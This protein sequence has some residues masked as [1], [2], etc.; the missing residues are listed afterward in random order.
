MELRDKNHPSILIWSLGNEAGAGASHAAM[1]GYLKE[2]DPTRP[3]QY[4]SQSPRGNISDI[5]CPMYPNLDWVRQVLADDSDLRP[6]IMC[7]YAYSKSNSNG[8]IHKHWAMTDQFPRF[9]G[10]FVWDFSDKA[11]I[12]TAADGTRQW[13]YGGDF[14]EKVTDPVLDMCLN[15][16]VG[17]DLAPHPGAFEIKKHQSPVRVFPG[18]LEQGVFEVRNTYHQSDL[19]H[20]RLI[21]EIQCD[22]ITVRTGTVEELA[23]LPGESATIKIPYDQARYCGECF[24]NFQLL[25]KVD[26]PWAERG[27]ELYNQQFELPFSRR[28]LP[29]RTVRGCTLQVTDRDQ[30]IL[31]SGPDCSVRFDKASGLITQAIYHG[32]Q[33]LLGG[34]DNFYRAPTGID[35]ACSKPGANYTAEWKALSLDQLQPEATDCAVT[36][37]ENAA[38]VK[39]HT[40]FNGGILESRTE[41]EIGGK[42]ILVRKK[43][44]VQKLPCS[45]PRIGVSFTLPQEFSQIEWFGR[46]PFENY[47]DRKLAANVGRYQSTV[48]EQNT[49]YILPVECGGKED[50]RWLRIHDGAGHGLKI[51]GGRDF[52]FDVH[53]NPV[54]DYE[55]A[56]HQSDLKPR[57]NV[58][59]N[60]DHL[61]MGIGGDTGWTKTVHPEYWINS[62]IYEYSFLIEPLD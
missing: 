54:Q 39:V 57:A 26:L 17:P 53:Y 58:F 12:R 40:V 44:L 43:V 6:F 33:L 24:I 11:L 9:Q 60:L 16:V 31:I 20:L 47:W 14:G 5:I 45:I 2:A 18:D 4:Q 41:Y 29:D 35:T 13:A 46:G 50:V 49:P 22:G 56:K 19:S 51:T 34:T 36:T 21:W 30:I 3:V 25:L 7:E 1:Y 55:A 38:L 8:N 37:A 15:G 28:T 61:H 27:F 59:L 42:G 48:A 23:A 10:G 32:R 62:G 52:H